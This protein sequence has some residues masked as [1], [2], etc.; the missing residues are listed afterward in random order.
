MMERMIRD[1]M[2]DHLML[3]KLVADEQ[4]GF[5]MNKSYLT[6]LMETIDIAFQA[7]DDGNRILIIFS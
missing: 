4:H 3:N 1:K 5:V 7:I 2:M 6:N